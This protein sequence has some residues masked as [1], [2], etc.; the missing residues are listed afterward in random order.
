MDIPIGQLTDL[1]IILAIAALV[2]LLID[3]LSGR[4]RFPGVVLEI[5]LGIVVGPSLLGWVDDGQLVEF[6]ANLGLA[7]LMFLA[8]Y[9]IDFLRLRGKPLNLAL[10]G[11]LASVAIGIGLAMLLDIWLDMPWMYVAFAISTTAIGTLLPILRDNG[12]VATRL[13]TFLL[14]AGAVGEF[15]PIVAVSLFLQG[16]RP[17]RTVVLLLIFAA[18][19]VL[20]IVLATRPRPAR[21][22][23]VVGTTLATSAQFAVRVAMLLLLGLVWAAEELGLDILLGAFAGGLIYRQFVRGG[24]EHEHGTVESKLDGIGFGFLIPV[25][26]VVS[27]VRFDADAL[28][29]DW[30]TLILL[31]LFLLLFL[32][33]RG[34]PAMVLYRRLLDDRQRAAFAFYTATQLPLVV[35]ISTL[36]VEA[37][38]LSS[39]TAAA[40][41][42]AGMLSVL[43]Y[44]LVASRIRG[45]LAEEYRIRAAETPA[46]PEL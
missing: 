34:V 12:E 38:R 36:G 35:V 19:A 14:A 44:P 10:A 41:V 26:F 11:W 40:M 6:V 13:G 24:P 25:F 4:L 1:V 2:P 45:P 16:H 9:E 46:V 3:A 27:G 22:A 39:G 5:G 33:C 7:M 32:V 23:R 42:G 37:G 29:S 31:P 28:L 21:F 18:I 43:I 30:Q 8:G 15:G 17:F 20:G